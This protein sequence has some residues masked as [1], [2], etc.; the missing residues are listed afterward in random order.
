MISWSP[1]LHSKRVVTRQL[2]RGNG[3]NPGIMGFLLAL[4]SGA[5]VQTR[6]YGGIQIE[7]LPLNSVMA[8]SISSKRGGMRQ[9]GV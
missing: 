7:D 9:D 8:A 5:A 6:Q 2:A 1:W 4:M 3:L